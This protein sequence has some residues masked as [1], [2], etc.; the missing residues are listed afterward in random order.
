MCN[1]NQQRRSDGKMNKDSSWQ[2]MPGYKLLVL[3]SQCRHLC[4]KKIK[5]GYPEEIENRQTRTLGPCS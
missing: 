5:D 4:F 1:S 3:S 2:D